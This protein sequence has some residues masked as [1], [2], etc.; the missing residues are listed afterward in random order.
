MICGLINYNKENK[1][2]LCKRPLWGLGTGESRVVFLLKQ[3]PIF[4]TFCARS[5]CAHSFLGTLLQDHLTWEQARACVDCS[6]NRTVFPLLPQPTQESQSRARAVDRTPRCES[7]NEARV[8]L[9]QVPAPQW[10]C[11]G[12]VAGCSAGARGGLPAPPARLRGALGAAPD[13]PNIIQS[14]ASALARAPG[15]SHR[16]WLPRPR[17]NP[18]GRGPEPRA[19]PLSQ[20]RPGPHGLLLLGLRADL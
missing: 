10:P 15:A 18:A 3:M 20:R 9:P 14:P 11:P 7:E 17:L 1:S 19:R 6:V 16:V 4:C 2:G 13:R 5:P 8:S 12:R